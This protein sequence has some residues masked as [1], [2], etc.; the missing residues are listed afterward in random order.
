MPGRQ[1]DGRDGGAL[2]LREA[3]QRVNLLDPLEVLSGEDSV[4][5]LNG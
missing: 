4:I 3:D 5:N 2:L 1:N